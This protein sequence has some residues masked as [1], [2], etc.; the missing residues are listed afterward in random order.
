MT[1]RDATTRSRLLVWTGAHQ[2]IEPDALFGVE[3][4]EHVFPNQLHLGT[5]LGSELTNKGFG[6]L[7]AVAQDLLHSFALFRTQ[8]D[9][10]GHPL[11]KVGT[12]K[13]CIR[14]HQSGALR[15]GTG[16]GALRGRRDQCEPNG[17][18]T[19]DHPGAKNDQGGQDD[20]EC[21]HHSSISTI[22]C[23]TEA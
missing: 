13:G 22:C 18:R 5:N 11:Q 16:L 10:P 23:S 17:K 7:V 14:H 9:L 3:Y 6:P 2:F 4:L 19:G 21:V 12:I 20:F 15:G 1:G 8:A